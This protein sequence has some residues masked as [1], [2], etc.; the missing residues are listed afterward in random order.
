M[1][2]IMTSIYVSQLVRVDI[3][4]DVAVLTIETFY[5]DDWSTYFSRDMLDFKRSNVKI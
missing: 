5:S 3:S 1:N 4:V 2:D